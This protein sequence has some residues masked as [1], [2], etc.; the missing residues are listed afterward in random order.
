[1]NEF[2]TQLDGMTVEELKELEQTIIKEA[3]EVDKE[4]VSKNFDMPEDNYPVVAEAVRYFLN[5]QQV[6]WQYTLGMVAMYDF[7]ADERPATIPF[8]Q[9]DSVLRALGSMQFTGYDEWARVI[10]INKY[11]EPLR[12]EYAEITERAY[13]VAE[14]HQLVMEKLGLNTPVESK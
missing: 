9:L 8:P 14:K 13:T 3:D 12:N 2:K 5:K 6:Q 1:M 11:F 7:W 4:I 10:A